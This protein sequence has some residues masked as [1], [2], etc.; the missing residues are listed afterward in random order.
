MTDIDIDHLRQWIGKQETAD[1]SVTVFPV[2]AMRATL[3]MEEVN[4]KAGEQLPPMWHALYFLP[5]SRQSELSSNGH[6]ELGGFMPPVPLPRRMYAGAGMQFHHPIFIGDRVSRTST[7]ADVSCKQGRTGNLVFLKIL[8][9]IAND[10]GIA[11]TEEQDIVYREE[12]GPGYTVTTPGS[13]PEDQAWIREM[14]ADPVLLFRY[15]ALT[16]NGHRIH[17]DQPY[18]T[19][20]EG[21]PGLVVHGPLLA[22]LLLDLLYRNA[23]GGP[24][25]NFRYRAIR[26]VINTSAF[27]L[28][29]RPEGDGKNIRLWVRD[30]AGALCL[31][32]GASIK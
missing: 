7:I 6:P 31:D 28:C 3:D 2:A 11:V 17:Y 32:A 18:T 15:S 1:D 21:Y 4:P 22:T 30:S 24:V 16:F 13:A 20:V 14:H 26:P 10:R 25:R 5:V 23:P 12:T 8:H 27:F 19:D 29:G 9:E